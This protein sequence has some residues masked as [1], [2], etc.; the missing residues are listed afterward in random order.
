M[1]LYRNS[2]D[3]PTQFGEGVAEVI[4]QFIDQGV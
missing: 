3:K 2:H 4:D 1:L